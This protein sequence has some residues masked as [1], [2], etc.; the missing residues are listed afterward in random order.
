MLKI[1]FIPVLLVLF[2]AC[3]AQKST[4]ETAALTQPS[5]ILRLE[6]DGTADTGRVGLHIIVREIATEEPVMSATVVAYRKKPTQAYGQLS[7]ADGDCNFNV[8]P[9]VYSLKIQLTGLSTFEK[10]GLVFE[11][12][13]HYTLEI[14]MG[15]VN[16]K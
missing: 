5:T 11:S 10:Q 6:A 9:G 3:A 14:G 2:N 1:A 8:A 7:S 13:R 4:P 12:G 15:K 16:I